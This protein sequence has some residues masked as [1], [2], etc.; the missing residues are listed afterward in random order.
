MS[1]VRWHH[2]MAR[3]R[4]NIHHM[5]HFADVHDSTSMD[6]D[7]AG[8]GSSEVCKDDVRCE[9]AP[10]L[11]LIQLLRPTRLCL[12]ELRLCCSA[13][14]PSFTVPDPFSIF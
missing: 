7:F 13:R 1:A 8:S 9:P 4:R 3:L 11:M 6:F 10:C 2:A 14:P 5:G 12:P